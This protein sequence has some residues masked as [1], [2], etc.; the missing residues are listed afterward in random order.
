MRGWG[1]PTVFGVQKRVDP[2]TREF[3]PEKLA[4]WPCCI[5]IPN[6]HNTHT[7]PP[8]PP[9]VR[10]ITPPVSTIYYIYIYNWVEIPAKLGARSYDM[11]DLAQS[12]SF[13]LLHFRYIVQYVYTTRFP[14]SIWNNVWEEMVLSTF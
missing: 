1:W 12:Y 8:P 6:T 10:P 3:W 13:T 14:T 4:V 11:C 5:S 7:P 9:F 2:Y